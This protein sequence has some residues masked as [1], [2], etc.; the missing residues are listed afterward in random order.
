MLYSCDLRKGVVYMCVFAKTEAGFYRAIEPV[1]FVPVSQTAELHR[2]VAETI[3]C[4]NPIIPTPRYEEKS[5]IESIILKHAGVKTWSA[6]E[7]G[8]LSWMMREKNGIYQIVGQRKGEYGGW[9]DDPE[10]TTTFPSGTSIDQAIDRLIEILQEAA[11]QH[12]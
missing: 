1:T 5:A 8:A 3:A 2:A 6:F 11:K 12:S 7:R 4:G 10:Q 9:V